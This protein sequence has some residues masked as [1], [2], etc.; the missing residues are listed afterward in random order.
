ML[1]QS[2]GV[3]LVKKKSELAIFGGWRRL[4]GLSLLQVKGVRAPNLYPGESVILVAGL[5]ISRN[6]FSRY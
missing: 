3:R 1:L 6:A 2:N 4:V 5:V